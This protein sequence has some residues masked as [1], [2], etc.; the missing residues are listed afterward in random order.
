MVY[1][2]VELIKHKHPRNQPEG[3]ELSPQAFLEP[4]IIALTTG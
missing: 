4:S 3:E 2:G 1:L